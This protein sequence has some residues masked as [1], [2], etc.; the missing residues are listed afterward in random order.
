MYKYGYGV[1]C[2]KK[3][4]K[5][6]LFF[7]IIIKHINMIINLHKKITG[8]IYTMSHPSNIETK[9]TMCRNG[10]CHKTCYMVRCYYDKQ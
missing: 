8:H 7:K 2:F 3:T 10:L 1:Y 9:E 6:I 5:F 4:L